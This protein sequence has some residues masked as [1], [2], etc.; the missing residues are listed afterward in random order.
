MRF[1]HILLGI[2]ALILITAVI[3]ISFDRIAVY[4]IAKTNNLDISY[5]NL[6]RSGR[7]FVFKDFKVTNKALGL[8]ISA[9]SAAIRPKLKGYDFALIDVRFLKK[10]SEEASSY[11]N[12][13]GLV[14]APFKGDWIYKEIEGEVVSSR[15]AIEV[16]KLN[17]VSDEIK[18]RISGTFRHDNTIDADIAIYFAADLTK[19]IPEELSKVILA[20]EG[21]GWRSLSVRLAGNYTKPSIQVSSKLFRLNIKSVSEK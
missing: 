1:Q 21:S 14:A 3:Y 13:A 11:E 5:Q 16:K 20:D 12:L 18:L 15:D 9:G 19:K 8:G 6:N 17:A 2:I 10:H 4:L 7:N